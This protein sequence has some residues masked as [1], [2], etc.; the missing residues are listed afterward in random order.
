[1]GFAVYNERPYTDSFARCP[2]CKK[3][4]DCLQL[5]YLRYGDDVHTTKLY[6]H[7]CGTTWKLNLVTG[8]VT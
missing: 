1:M 4:V 7:K 2:T 5:E 3:S 6:H 8:E